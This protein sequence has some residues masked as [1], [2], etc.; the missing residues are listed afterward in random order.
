M[1]H[2][3]VE[4]DLLEGKKHSSRTACLCTMK[5]HICS[6]INLLLVIIDQLA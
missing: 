2:E 6:Y 5:I 1:S 4:T 3:K